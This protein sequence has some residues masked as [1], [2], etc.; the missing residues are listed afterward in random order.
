MGAIRVHDESN[1]RDVSGSAYRI[2]LSAI[3][4]F[5]NRLFTLIEAHVTE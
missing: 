1:E 3:D 4:V 5:S 2:P